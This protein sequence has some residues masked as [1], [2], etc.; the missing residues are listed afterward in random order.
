M[1][2]LK[3]LPFILACGLLSACAA[4]QTGPDIDYRQTEPV[5]QMTSAGV[6]TVSAETPYSQTSL[7]SALPQLEMGTVK[8]ISEGQLKNLYAAFAG[9]MQQLQFEPDRTGNKVW[10]VHLVGQEAAGPNGERVGMTFAQ[11]GGANLNC[12]PG[13]NQ[14]LSMALCMNAERT[15]T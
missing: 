3:K 7:A 14:W 4:T 2:A 6:G 13:T 9:G 5:I 8:T 12:E 1:S 11:S 15:L 10:R